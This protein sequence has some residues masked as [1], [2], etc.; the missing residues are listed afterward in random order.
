MSQATTV[1][2][3]R[4][5]LTVDPRVGG[6]GSVIVSLPILDETGANLYDE[7]GTAASNVLW[8]EIYYAA[9]SSAEGLH[10]Y[11]RRFDLT[12]DSRK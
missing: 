9:A 7:A 5:D 1:S 8:D 2:K 10:V 12:V 4:F 11:R 3:R 6:F